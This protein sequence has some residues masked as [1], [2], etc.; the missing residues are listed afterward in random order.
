MNWKTF[1]ATGLEL[2]VW[3]GGLLALALMNPA[4]NSHFSLCLFNWL[5]FTGCPGCGIGH[6]VSWL[7][8]GNLSASWQSHPLGV[9]AVPVLAHR[10]YTLACKQFILINNLNQRH[11][12]SR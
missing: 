11:A 2:L 5:G 10:I 8:H 4:S 3:L 7:F 1:F 9:F 12:N 6:A